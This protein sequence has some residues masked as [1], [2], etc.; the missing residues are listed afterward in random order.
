TQRSDCGQWCMPGGAAEVGESPSQAAVRETWEETGLRVRARRLLG[1][2]DNRR[3]Y[4]E[5]PGY[6]A[7]P[8]QTYNTVF[9]AIVVDGEPVVTPETVAVGWFTVEQARELTLFRS[10]RVKVFDVFAIRHQKKDAPV[11]H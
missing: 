11:F 3:L 2:Y 1:L 5:D 9:E 10:H 4:R 8:V 7:P 6:D